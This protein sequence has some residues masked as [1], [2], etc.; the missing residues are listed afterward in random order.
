MP[1]LKKT[2]NCVGPTIIVFCD[3]TVSVERSQAKPPYGS[4][5]VYRKANLGIFRS[6]FGVPGL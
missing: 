1:S 6:I 2:V 4:F 5:P 3:Y